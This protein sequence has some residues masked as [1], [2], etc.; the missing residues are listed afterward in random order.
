MFWYSKYRLIR[1]LYEL[2]NNHTTDTIPSSLVPPIINL[3]KLRSTSGNCWNA[4]RAFSLKYVSFV[5]QSN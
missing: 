1:E 5:A 3:T 2:Q 4:Q